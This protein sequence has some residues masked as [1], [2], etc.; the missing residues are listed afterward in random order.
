MKKIYTTLL[1]A[2]SLFATG[3]SDWLDVAP[4]NQVNEDKLFSSADGYRNA[5]NGVYLN[6][7]TSSLYGQTLSWG[8]LDVIAQYYESGSSYMQSSSAYYKAARYQ[9]D[10]SDVKT[11]VSNIWENGYKNIANCNNLI[12]NISK[13]S[14]SLFSEGELERDMIWGEALALRALM[15]FDILRLFAPAMGQ[16]DGKAYIPYVDV[17]PTIVPTY[18]TNARVLEKVVQDLEDAKRLLAN[19]DLTEEHKVWMS[20]GYRMLGSVLA[21]DLAANDV[22]FAFRGYR[23]NYYAVTALL[24]RV[25]N[26]AGRHE[27]AY[28]CAKEV[29]EATYPDGTESTADCFDFAESLRSNPKDYNSIIFTFFNATLEEDYSSY[30]SSENSTVFVVNTADLFAEEVSVDDRSLDLFGNWD[31]G[32]IKYLSKYDITKGNNGSDMIPGIR[33]SEMYYIMAEYYAQQ[34]QYPTAGEMLDKVRYARGI[35]TTNLASAINSSE[36]FYSYLVS[37]MR[38][39]FVGEGQMFYQYKRLN[40]KPADNVVFVLEK[41]ESEDI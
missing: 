23:M 10:D 24:A 36:S 15:H 18:E 12:L 7:G 17:Y 21:D 37:E 22:F 38:R 20:T 31:G 30:I 14:P 4:S 13:A 3:C 6:L 26:W 40:T 29:A 16:D 8:F 5:L 9:F 1:F 19:C 32:D 11:F 33:L 34:G 27:E 35:S 28:N 2:I 25:Y 41:P 39:E